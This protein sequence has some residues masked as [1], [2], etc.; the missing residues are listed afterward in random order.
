[1]ADFA[2]RE[3]GWLRMDDPEGRSV[4]VQPTDTVYGR[5]LHRLDRKGQKRA[6]TYFAK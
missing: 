1:L 2:G 5:S 6:T 3:L 4:P